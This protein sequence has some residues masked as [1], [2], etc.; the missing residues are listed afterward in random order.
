MLLNK[1]IQSSTE[2][3]E[4]GVFTSY[5]NL[6]SYF[7]IVRSGIDISKISQ[8]RVDGILLVLL[9]RFFRFRVIRRSFDFTSDAVHVFNKSAQLNLSIALVGGTEGTAVQAAAIFSERFG[10]II[11]YARSGFFD[12]EKE[13]RIFCHRLVEDNVDVVII[14]MGAVK[15]EEFMLALLDCGYNGSVYSCGG[16]FHQTV[17]H[18][19]VYYPYLM[20][21]LNL[22]WLYRI[23]DEPKLLKRYVL[24][25]PIATFYVLKDVF[26]FYLRRKKG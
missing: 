21:R 1:I 3:C 13:I 5:V 7:K 2:D 17:S 15:Q 9:L 10:V 23:W 16:F 8:F 20:D 22:R 11:N 26:I 14:G 25:Y 18:G 24:M 6:F 4:S 12:S 19:G